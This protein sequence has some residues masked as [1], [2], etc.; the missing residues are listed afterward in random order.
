[1]WEVEEEGT[2]LEIH[3]FGLLSHPALARTEL[4]S[5]AGKLF[6]FLIHVGRF[7]R[8]PWSDAER[9]LRGIP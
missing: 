5:S 9:T 1:M 4:P 2:Q 8:I 3:V 6:Y 7:R